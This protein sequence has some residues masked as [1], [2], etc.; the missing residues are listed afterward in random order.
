MTD[1]NIYRHRYSLCCGLCTTVTLTHTHTF[2][3]VNV[4]KKVFLLVEWSIQQSL[5][6]HSLEGACGFL[7]EAVWQEFVV[8]APLHDGF[9]SYGQ[10]GAFLYCAGGSLNVWFAGW[11]DVTARMF[12]TAVPLGIRS[13]ITDQVGVGALHGERSLLAVSVALGRLSDDESE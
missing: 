10:E 7:L 6:Q 4:D 1:N 9:S 5:S 13:L 3:Q 12:P 2:C 11:N 8:S